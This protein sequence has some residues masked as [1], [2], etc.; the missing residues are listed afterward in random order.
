MEESQIN[1]FGTHIKNL[2][3]SLTTF[4]KKE[5]GENIDLLKSC[6]NVLFAGKPDN[7]MGE[8]VESFFVIIVIFIGITVFFVK[9]FRIPTGSMQPSLN[10]IIIHACEEMPSIAERAINKLRYGSSY[11]DEKAE[12]HMSIVKY[13]SGTKFFIFTT[14]SVVFD[15]GTKIEIPCAQGEVMRY[16]TSHKGRPTASFSPGDTI[17]KARIDAG[18]MI[19]VNRMAYHFRK[20]KLGETF[21]F[22]TR[23]QEGIKRM[24]SYDQGGGT[25]YVKRLCGLPGNTI[26]IEKPNLFINGEIPHIWTLSRVAHRKPPYNKSG[27][28][29]AGAS[30]YALF[31][32]E[33][34]SLK[35]N[36][37]L[38][39]PILNEYCALG[40]NTENSLDSRYW[41]T[42]KQYNIIGPASFA[43][44]P[45]T[46]HWGPIP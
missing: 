40:D 45:F 32:G 5:T 13:V 21:V 27:Y 18:D 12:R 24:S 17:I 28:I 31:L 6:N 9:P 4:R 15:D 37:N 22:D 44:W 35:L 30:K 19:F 11:I 26:K 34:Q 29:P 43:L 33:G 2:R 41:G 36:K 7:P 16:F 10:G 3:T 1:E 46:S 23:D 20:P 39:N 25:H 38:Q 8:N 42:V 14:T